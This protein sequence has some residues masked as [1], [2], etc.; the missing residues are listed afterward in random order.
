L[1]TLGFIMIRC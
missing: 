1:K